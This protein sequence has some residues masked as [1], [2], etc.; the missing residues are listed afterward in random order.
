[1]YTRLTSPITASVIPSKG[2][3]SVNSNTPV[4]P[5]KFE[6]PDTNLSTT[7]PR[8]IGLSFDGSLFPSSVALS[9][10]SEVKCDPK[11][12]EHGRDEHRSLLYMPGRGLGAMVSVAEFLLPWFHVVKFEKLVERLEEK[13]YPE[14]R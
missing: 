4:Y 14:V 13:S 2:T 1:M 11:T 12:A 5:K 7:R 10:P 8:I 3:L 9:P 6:P